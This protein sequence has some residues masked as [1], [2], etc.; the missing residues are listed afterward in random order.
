MFA[1]GMVLLASSALLAPWL[2]VLG[3]YPVDTAGLLL[4]P[5]GIGTMLAMLVA[6]RLSNKVD[7]RSVM[8]FG[9]LLLWWSMTAVR[10][11]SG[12]GRLDAGNQYDRAGRR[13]RL[14]LRAAERRRLRHA[15]GAVALR[16]H[17]VDQPAAQY[18]QRDRHLDLRGAA[19]HGAEVEHSVLAPFASPLNRALRRRRPS[20]TRCRRCTHGAAVLD[21][22]INYQA[23]VIAYNNDYLADGDDVAAVPFTAA[24]DAP[25]AAGRHWAAS[26]WRRLAC[27]RL[28]EANPRAARTNAPP[29]LA[30]A[31]MRPSIAIRR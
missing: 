4:A 16:R 1:I 2:Q 6:G 27:N 3:N 13:S 9:V 30:P 28:T 8:A 5:R 20:R 29:A 26:R 19:D 24:V 7:P 12:G 14:G 31:S 22:M 15:A 21:Q 11:D 18:R 23:Q 10:L 25:A 17:R